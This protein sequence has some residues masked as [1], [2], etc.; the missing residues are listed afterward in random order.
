MTT[1]KQIEKEYD[2]LVD[3]YMEYRTWLVERLIEQIDRDHEKMKGTGRHE[4]NLV[5]DKTNFK[6]ESEL[7][8][9]NAGQRFAMITAEHDVEREI[10]EAEEHQNGAE[11]SL[12][13]LKKFLMSRATTIEMGDN[14]MKVNGKAVSDHEEIVKIMSAMAKI[15]EMTEE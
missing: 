10:Q 8:A 2:E 12:N 13:M 4:H 14:G 5:L 7:L 9:M 11:E 3:L 6:T 15:V 1:Q